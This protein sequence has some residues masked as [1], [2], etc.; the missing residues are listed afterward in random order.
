MS[1]DT[2]Q[3]RPVSEKRIAVRVTPDA[4]R[5]IR[6]GHPWVYDQS[7]TS[8]S[9]DSSPGDL[10]VVFDDNRDFAAIGLWD[11]QSPIRLKILHT[12]RPTTIDADFW[13][14]RLQAAIAIRADIADDL[15]NTGFRVVHGENDGL[16]GLVLDEYA[17][18][19]V[20]KLYTTAWLPH[21]RTIVPL[22]AELLEPESLVL[23]LSRNIAEQMPDSLHEGSAL[24]GRPPTEPV[25]IRENGLR[26]E[27]HPI[28]GQKTG[29]FL[30]H[31]DNRRMVRDLAEGARVLDMF[32]CSGGFSIHAAAGGARKVH[33]VDLSG[34]AIET[35]RR[36]MAH[37]ASD[38]RIAAC[39]HQLTVGDAFETM[40]GLIDRNERFDMV[41]VDPPSFAQ[42]KVNVPAAL[43]AYAKLTT[44]AIELVPDGG[45]LVQ[46]SCSSRVSA[47][48]FHQTVTDAAAASS[49]DLD[50]IERTSHCV[51]HP[52]GFAQ[53]AYLKAVFATV[54]KGRSPNSLIG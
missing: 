36:N 1:F 40:H 11:P 27:S 33:S 13:R 7:I 38:P 17:D 24:I 37:N 3:L 10:A 30:D 46:A 49:A 19:A 50:V 29:Y 25:M 43:R 44:L 12:G 52:V 32:S 47:E 28:T 20:L 42:R 23:R 26:F 48:A 39:E 34:H 5:Q 16:P 41:I 4:L 21:L 6:G 18:V 8:I 14:T 2:T 51:D 31:R 9:H 22:I 35:A 54:N 45:I 53:G 15:G